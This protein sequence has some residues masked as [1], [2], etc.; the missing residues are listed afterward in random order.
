MHV[1]MLFDLKKKNG[2]IEE[3]AARGVL[4]IWEDTGDIGIQDTEA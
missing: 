1:L 3:I 4:A 2:R